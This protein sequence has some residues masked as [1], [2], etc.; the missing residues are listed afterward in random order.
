MPAILGKCESATKHNVLSNSP[1]FVD[2]ADSQAIV[3]SLIERR[4][5]SDPLPH[6]IF[7]SMLFNYASLNLHPRIFN[8]CIPDMFA[9]VL[10]RAWVQLEGAG[11]LNNRR[12]GNLSTFAE[13][14]LQTVVYGFNSSHA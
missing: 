3:A 2:L 10:E 7:A 5:K 11:Q 1:S 12:M 14:F 6:I 4:L 8:A 9:G 13:R